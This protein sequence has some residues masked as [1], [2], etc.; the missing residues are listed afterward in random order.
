MLDEP[1]FCALGGP[2]YSWNL[3]VRALVTGLIL[4]FFLFLSFPG[5]SDLL[6]WA[7][8]SAACAAFMDDDASDVVLVVNGNGLGINGMIDELPTTDWQSS[9]NRLLV[10][11][12]I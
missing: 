4:P 8:K 1:F 3:I 11:G 2:L 9:A 6:V 7:D 5:A 12:L 10:S